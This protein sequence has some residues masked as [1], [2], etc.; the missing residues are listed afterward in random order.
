MAAQS[1]NFVSMLSF[2]SELAAAFDSL[3][4]EV[5]AAH[6][7]PT[8]SL[9]Y[10]STYFLWNLGSGCALSMQSLHVVFALSGPSGSEQLVVAEN[11]HDY[12]VTGADLE[13]PNSQSYASSTSSGS[14]WSGWGVEAS[15]EPGGD[16][17]VP[18]LSLSS[19]CDTPGCD[20]DLWIGQTHVYGGGNGASGTGIAQTGTDQILVINNLGT[21]SY[22]YFTWYEFYQ[23]SNSA[24]T[25]CFETYPGD[26][27]SA[28]TEYL[29][30]E[31]YYTYI[32]DG[33]LGE[34]CSATA[35]MSMGSPSYAWFME[36]QQV[37]S[38]GGLYATPPFTAVWFNDLGIGTN[39]DLPGYST[40]NVTSA[41]DVM[42]HGLQYGSANCVMFWSCFEE[43]YT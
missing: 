40:F 16:W 6:G 10:S 18:T 11:P 33:T 23:N 32:S 2:S 8:E 7:G 20:L 9:R 43:T 27:I 14:G 41:S 37:D 24:E 5:V 42:D 22:D 12:E 36:E 15:G 17:K 30:G 29:G 4:F 25:S 26:A 34:A 1:E 35:S 21:P 38:S 39:G 13:I 28:T 19:K 31:D 3:P